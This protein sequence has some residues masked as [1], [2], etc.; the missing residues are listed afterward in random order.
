MSPSLRIGFFFMTCGQSVPQ[1]MR[2]GLA[3][4]SWRAGSS[5]SP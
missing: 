3:A 2:S 1:I 5:V 4:T